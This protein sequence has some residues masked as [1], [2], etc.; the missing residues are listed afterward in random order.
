[1]ALS[2]TVSKITQNY[3]NHPKPFEPPETCWADSTDRQTIEIKVYTSDSFYNILMIIWKK[4]ELLPHNSDTCSTPCGL[5][6]FEKQ[7]LCL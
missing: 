7:S 2:V 4:E 1:M 6:K 3:L 5:I